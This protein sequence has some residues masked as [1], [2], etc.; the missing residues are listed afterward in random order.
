MP[1]S[2]QSNSG[3]DDITSEEFFD[4]F[5]LWTEHMPQSAEDWIAVAERTLAADAAT[6]E[7]HIL[8]EALCLAVRQ[9]DEA[10]GA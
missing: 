2:S 10:R 4:G 1:D 6:N 3:D 8:F 9:R 7:G 5:A